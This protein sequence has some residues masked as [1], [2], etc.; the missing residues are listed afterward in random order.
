[1]FRLIRFVMTAVFVTLA[2][3]AG[4][5]WESLSADNRCEAAGGLPERGICL[6]VMR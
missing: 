3:M 4:V 6:G 5:V 2:F 1:M